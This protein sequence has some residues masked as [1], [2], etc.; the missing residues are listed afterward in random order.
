MPP[1]NGKVADFE[2]YAGEPGLSASIMVDLQRVFIC[3][4]ID[5]ETNDLQYLEMVA[6][7]AAKFSSKVVL[8]MSANSEWRTG[9]SV[10]HET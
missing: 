9:C 10:C 1:G 4:D 6:R 8:P 2:P 3:L 7:G 5:N